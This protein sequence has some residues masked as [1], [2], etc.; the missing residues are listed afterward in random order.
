M[1]DYKIPVLAKISS[2]FL[3]VSGLFFCFNFAIGDTILGNVIV[4]FIS[5]ITGIVSLAT[6]I[7]AI[8]KNPKSV[9]SYILLVLSLG[10]LVAIFLLF[11]TDNVA[12]GYGP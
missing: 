10:I 7:G 1:S 12:M 11:Y 6:S 9:I 2:G 4:L 5:G 8:I 3:I